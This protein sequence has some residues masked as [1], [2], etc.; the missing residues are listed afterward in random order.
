MNTLI[1]LVCVGVPPKAENIKPPKSTPVLLALPLVNG[2][3]VLP[4]CSP[5][6]PRLI[7]VPA[8]VS[9]NPP[10]DSVTPLIVNPVASAVNVVS[11]TVNMD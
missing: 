11:P 7:T 6:V 10:G 5:P 8:I 4:I 3:V 9:G 1:T 2:S